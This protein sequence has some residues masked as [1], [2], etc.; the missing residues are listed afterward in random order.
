[1]A[2]SVAI[3]YMLFVIL[4]DLLFNGKYLSFRLVTDLYVGRDRRGARLD[5]NVLAVL[6]YV[7]QFVVGTLDGCFKRPYVVVVTLLRNV[8]DDLIDDAAEFLV[9]RCLAVTELLRLLPFKL[10]PFLMRL[11][12]H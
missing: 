6:D 11:L 7:H 4:A 1:M 3:G 8:R 5:C 12:L 2:S 10:S 9:I